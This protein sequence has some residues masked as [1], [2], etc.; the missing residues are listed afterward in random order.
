MNLGVAGVGHAGAPFVGTPNRGRIGTARVGGEVEDVAVA[1]GGE[2]DG[3]G[4]VARNRARDEVA[5][6]D[7][8]GLAVHDHEI[9]HLGVGMQ[10]HRTG[11]DRAGQRRVSAEKQLLPRLTAGVK[12]ARDLRSAEGAVGQQATVF[13][14]KGHALRDTLVDDVDRHF[15]EAMDVGLAGPV[16]AAFQR[17]VKKPMNAVAVVLVILGGVDPALRR[18]GVGTARAVVEHEALHLVAEVGEGGRRRRTG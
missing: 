14:G 17:I 3:I 2:N 13:A 8:F 16:V 4:R 5:D 15:G 9:E 18:D 10:V 6:D 12:R 1:A 11:T 7:A